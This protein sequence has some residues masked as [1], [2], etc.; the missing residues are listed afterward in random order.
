MLDANRQLGDGFL[1]RRPV[2]VVGGDLLKIGDDGGQPGGAQVPEIGAIDQM[3]NRSFCLGPLGQQLERVVN[4]PRRRV[5]PQA[6]IRG[7]NLVEAQTIGPGQFGGQRG[8]RV[9]GAGGA[10]QGFVVGEAVGTA[11]VLIGAELEVA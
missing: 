4:V 11:Q 3:L 10:E 8:A 1:H 6:A 7:R 9:V 2:R 5:T